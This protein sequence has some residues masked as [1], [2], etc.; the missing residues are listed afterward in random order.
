MLEVESGL[1]FI[2][3]NK[4]LFL[5]IHFSLRYLI[6]VDLLYLPDYLLL[7]TYAQDT[8]VLAYQRPFKEFGSEIPKR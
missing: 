2:S 4:G 6:L 1:L 5:F 7:I 3:T 8:H